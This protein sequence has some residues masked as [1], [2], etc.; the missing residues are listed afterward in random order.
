MNTKTEQSVAKFLKHIKKM[1]KYWAS[2][3]LSDEEKL[4][5]LAFSML[6]L[7]DGGDTN[8]MNGFKVV[9]KST[10]IDVSVGYL[11]EIKNKYE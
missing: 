8:F 5:G 10:G 6:V 7:F 11:H 2:Q 4:G 9:D 1:E 3:K